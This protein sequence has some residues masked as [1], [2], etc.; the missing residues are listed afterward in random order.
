MEHSRSELVSPTEKTKPSTLTKHATAPKP[1]SLVKDPAVDGKTKRTVEKEEKS[2]II[3]AVKQNSHV[4]I[5][6]SRWRGRMAR[7][8]DL[9]KSKVVPAPLPLDQLR[10]RR[11]G[12]DYTLTKRSF[13][14]TKRDTKLQRVPLERISNIEF[15]IDSA[16]GLPY[17]S[18]VCRVSAKLLTSKMTQIG[19][20]TFPPSYSHPDS[21][22]TSPSFAFRGTWK[23][24]SAY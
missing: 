12:T 21:D 19:G 5:I 4:T 9:K 10:L 14:Q 16:G 8:I 1:S 13:V 15:H 17:S 6:Q 24:N 3:N 20:E 18:T 22:Y 2:K 23:G 11:T 7:L